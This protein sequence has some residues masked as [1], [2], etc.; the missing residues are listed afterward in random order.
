V[1]RPRARSFGTVAGAYAEHRP[2]YPGAA[3][4]WVLRSITGGRLVD[5]AAGTG[6]LTAALL[7][8]GRV[9]AVEP[10]P[11]MIDEL[12]RRFPGVEAVAGTAEAIPLPAASVDA[13]LVGQAWH[14][15]DAERALPELARVLRPGGVLAA[16][17]NAD[18]T[19]VEWVAG[20]HQAAEQGRAVRGVPANGIPSDFAEHVAF[21]PG[22]EASFPNP[23][24]TT[25][26]GLIAS[27][28]T[29]SWA[30][31][32]EPAQRDAAFARVR[33]YL[34]ERPETSSGA[35]VLP[36]TTEVLRAFRR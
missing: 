23:I 26:D 27:I 2:G 14:W 25:T 21:E 10:D 11:A 29:H 35:F 31:I 32:S 20:L 16:L 4:D 22:G 24:R 18:D 6:K 19:G 3:V 9:T 36:M 17:W 12:R 13:V 5:L 34:A 15:F 33:S 30:L 28:G 8:R 7:G 1:P